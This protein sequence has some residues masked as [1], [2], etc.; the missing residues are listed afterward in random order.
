[1]RVCVCVCELLVTFSDLSDN[2]IHHCHGPLG[3]PALL[4]G[5]VFLLLL[6][7][8]GRQIGARLSAVASSLLRP[9]AVGGCIAAKRAV[10]T[11]TGHLQ[12]LGTNRLPVTRIASTAGVWVR[13]PSLPAWPGY[14]GDDADLKAPRTESGKTQEGGDLKGRAAGHHITPAGT[15]QSS[16]LIPTWCERLKTLQQLRDFKTTR[17]SGGLC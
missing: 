5:S 17:K 12:A 9:P 2:C 16:R 13:V 3:L 6:T 11:V 15:R 8:A 7:A 4:V 14:L 1:M 10:T